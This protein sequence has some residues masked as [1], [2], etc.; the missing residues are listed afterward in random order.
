MEKC[1]FCVHR[2][3]EGKNKAKL[4]KRDLQDGDIKTACQ[5]VC[6][7]NAIVFGDL[8]NENTAV[9]KMFKDARGYALLEEFHAAPNVRYLSKIR[10]NGQAA[11]NPGA[12]GGEHGSQEG[13]HS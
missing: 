12:H 10:N 1:S 9:A 6:P 13:G 4:E 2:I 8:N 3:K 7:T 5:Q 11:R